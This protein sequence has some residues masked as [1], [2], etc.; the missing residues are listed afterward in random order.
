MLR[1]GWFL[2]ALVFLARLP[3]FPFHLFLL[4]PHYGPLC[5]LVRYQT[6]CLSTLHTLYP[7]RTCHACLHS[8]TLQYRA[9]LA[10]S[11]V[12]CPATSPESSLSGSLSSPRLLRSPISPFQ[13]LH[14]SAPLQV[15][16][17]E[18][19]SPIAPALDRPPLVSPLFFLTLSLFSLSLFLSFSASP[20]PVLSHAVHVLDLSTLSTPFLPPRPPAC[21]PF[22]SAIIRAARPRPNRV[23]SRPV[24]FLISSPTR[25]RLPRTRSQ[26]K[27]PRSKQRHRARDTNDPRPPTASARLDRVPCAC[28]SPPSIADPTRDCP[29]HH[30]NLFPASRH[31]HRRRHHPRHRD[32]GIV[33]RLLSLPSV[34]VAAASYSKSLAYA[35]PHPCALFS[36]SSPD[37]GRVISDCLSSH[38][39]FSLSLSFV[40]ILPS[41]SHLHH[42]VPSTLFALN[43]TTSTTR[44]Y[45][46]TRPRRR[47]SHLQR[48]H[49]PQFARPFLLSSNSLQL[50]LR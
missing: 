25:N 3:F 22:S 13:R 50:S 16:S 4:P 23:I 46:P 40:S 47:K 21:V 45:F 35:V 31:R 19:Q 28:S 8:N 1:L 15:A 42:P 39:L 18:Y 26:R 29:G 2:L 5:Y 32:I 24:C 11:P 12:L 14:C 41:F 38:A 37:D 30:D 44:L 48:L 6:L 10:G 20:Y 7:V 36:P 43:I 27:G 33:Y 9:V 49:Q 17:T 34:V